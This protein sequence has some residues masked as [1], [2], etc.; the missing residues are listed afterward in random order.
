MFGGG[1]GEKVTITSRVPRLFLVVWEVC[2]LGFCVIFL[3]TFGWRTGIICTTT[4]TWLGKE[5]KKAL[6]ETH[7]AFEVAAAQTSGLVHSSASI[8][9]LIN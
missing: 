8:R 9:L 1:E 2:K 5:K 7:Y 3:F 6:P 4:K